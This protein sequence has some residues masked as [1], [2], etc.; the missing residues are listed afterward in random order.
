MAHLTPARLV[1][2][3]EGAPTEDSALHLAACD[4]CRRALS[5]LRATMADVGGAADP[6]GRDVPEP[7]P[8]F[9]DHFSDRVRDRVAEQGAPRPTWVDRWLRPRIVLPIV[10]TVAG[11][12]MLTIVVPR[13][14]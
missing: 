10:A 4:A 9:W 7:S 5:E 11:A 3:A 13:R 14:P 2:L 12:I 8:L 1:D 6:A